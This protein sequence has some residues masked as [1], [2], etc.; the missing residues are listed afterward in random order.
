MKFNLKIFF[1]GLVSFGLVF[2]VSVSLVA[3]KVEASLKKEAVNQSN[4]FK[5][6]CENLD[7]K[8]NGRDC[9]ISGT[10]F[11][12]IHREKIVTT[13]KSINGI[14]NVTDD[15]E[16]L[17]LTLPELRIEKSGEPANLI[18]K[19]EGIISDGPNAE[20]LQDVLAKTLSNNNQRSLSIELKKDSRTANTLPVEKINSLLSKTFE[21]LPEV[22]AV[23]ISENNFKLTAKTYSKERRDQVLEFARSHLGDSINGV[24]DAIEILEPTD[25]PKLSIT[26]ENDDDLIVSGLLA[27]ASLKNRIV[28]LI[29]QTNQELNLKD[30]IKVEDNVRSAEWGSSVVRIV[31]ALIAEVNDLK[32]NVSSD[33]VEFSGTVLGDDKKD[34]IQ[35][36]AK[37]SFDGKKSSFKLINEL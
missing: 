27:D 34:S 18:W 13:I 9:S 10:I 21:I 15:L 1:L 3:P 11:D 28:E 20:N 19:I 35:T 37:Q 4:E 25:A 22:S 14:R 16:V 7:F 30:E 24:I 29:K 33:A 2:W 5:E 23:E 17:Q 36:L 8:F 12:E 32:F 6:I 26:F 31:P